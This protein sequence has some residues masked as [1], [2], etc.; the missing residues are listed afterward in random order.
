MNPP[1]AL[2]HSIKAFFFSVSVFFFSC[3][4]SCFFLVVVLRRRSLGEQLSFDGRELSLSGEVQELGAALAVLDDH[5]GDQRGVDLWLQ[6]DVLG[7]GELL[8]LL[9]DLELLV[10][11]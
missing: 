8:Q 1:N 9:G 10:V 3:F 5:S 7:A 4:S 2:D 11:V 6:L